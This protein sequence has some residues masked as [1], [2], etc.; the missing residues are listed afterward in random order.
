MYN[1]LIKYN[2]IY[3]ED[4]PQ[5]IIN[6]YCK[7]KNIKNI[8]NNQIEVKNRIILETEKKY[9]H[10][11]IIYE[12]NNLIYK[13]FNFKDTCLDV[14]LSQVKY[15]KFYIQA[16]QKKFYNNIALV[17]K[18]IYDNI[19]NE[20][21]GYCAFKLQEIKIYDENK[22]FDLVDRLVLQFKKTGLI[23]TDLTINTKY[24]SNIMEYNNKYY[25]IDLESVCDL[26]TYLK[27]KDIRFK[28]NSKYYEKKILE[29]YKFNEK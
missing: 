28:N 7:S 23:F 3:L 21:I 5:N 13:I 20:Y 12:S 17:H 8:P 22:F 6:K 18:Y 14:F 15:D 27:Y 16:I 2:L 9:S 24:K 11:R 25:I 26:K 4:L 1:L 19:N 10:Y 29:N